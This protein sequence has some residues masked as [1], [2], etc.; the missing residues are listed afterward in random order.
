MTFG[1][2]K[3]KKRRSSLCCR[4]W[5]PL[6]NKSSAKTKG[7]PQPTSLSIVVEVCLNSG[8]WVTSIFYS[9]IYSCQMWIIDV[10]IDWNFLNFLLQPLWL[11]VWHPKVPEIG[12]CKPTIPLLKQMNHS[13]CWPPWFHDLFKQFTRRKI[14]IH[15]PHIFLGGILAEILNHHLM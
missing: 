4:L 6:V 7:R 5:V 15:F 10:Q 1:T 13:T 9:Y 3:W 8:W 2:C 12:P 14:F 11:A